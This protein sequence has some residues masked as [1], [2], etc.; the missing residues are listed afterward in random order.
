MSGKQRDRPRL[1]DLLACWW[2]SWGADVLLIAGAA[3]ITAGAAA[4]YPPAGAIVGGA[5]L[6][7]GGVLLALG[8]RGG[9][10]E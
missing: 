7:A 4:I 5:F 2:D 3:A 10:D 1:R 9:D 8:S 6:V